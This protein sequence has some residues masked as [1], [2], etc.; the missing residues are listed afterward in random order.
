MRAGR[1]PREA[2]QFERVVLPHLDAAYNLARWLLGDRHDAQDVVQDACLQAFAAFDRFEERSPRAWLLTIVRRCALRRLETGRRV[3]NVVAFDETLHSP[4]EQSPGGWT[5]PTAPDAAAA[6]RAELRRVREALAA[7]PGPLREVIV[8]RELEE[9]SYREIAAVA[10]VP[11]GTVMSRLARARQR[12][13]ATL[14]KD[15]QQREGGA[16]GDL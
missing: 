3:S 7:L 12:L 16:C 14:A 2:E 6:Q 4:A 8:L 15:G 1:R 13:R 10:G 9:L 11:V 5:G